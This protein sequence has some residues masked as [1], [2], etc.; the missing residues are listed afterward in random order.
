VLFQDLSLGLALRILM[1]TIIYHHLAILILSVDMSKLRLTLII[2]S[3][4]SRKADLRQLTPEAITV[5]ITDLNNRL[6][7]LLRKS[8][9]SSMGGVSKWATNLVQ[10]CQIAFQH[11]LPLT[12]NEHAFLDQLLDQGIIR[13]ELLSD[14][15]LFVENVKNH[16]AIKWAAQQSKEN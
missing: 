3:A 1:A 10:E 6:L 2:Y 14:N 7:P 13:P 15:V 8:E 12:E 9:T 4:I 11:F 16:P 5:D